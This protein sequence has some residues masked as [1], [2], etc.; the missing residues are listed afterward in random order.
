MIGRVMDR[1]DRPAGLV[2]MIAA[3]ALCG[4]VVALPL[5]AAHTPMMVDMPFHTAASSVFRHYF[6]PEWHFRE[7]FEL[8]LLQVP[9]LSFYGLIAGLMTLF[10]PLVATR[11]AIAVMLSMVPA[12]LAI[13]AWGLKKS[14]LLGLLG[15]FPVWG[16]LTHWGFINHMAAL[17][18][19]AACVGLALRLTQRP[20]RG[21]RWALGATLVLILFTHVYR[22]PFA[23]LAALGAGLFMWPDK[24]KLKPLIWPL[25]VSLLLFLIWLII[26]PATIGFNMG[27]GWPDLA[28]LTEIEQFLYDAFKG[29]EDDALYRRAVVILGAAAAGLSLGVVIRR[30]RRGWTPSAFAKRSHLLV[31]ACAAGFLVLYLIFPTWIGNWFYVYPRAITSAVVVG[32]ALIPNLPSHGLVRLGF[33]LIVGVALVPV[34]RH[35][36]EAHVEFAETTD[37]MWELSEELPHAPKLQYLIFNHSGAKIHQTPYVH[38]PAYLQAVHGGWLGWQFAWLGG[39]PLRFPD[40]DEPGAGVPPGPDAPWVWHPRQFEVNDEGAFFDWFL[41]RSKKDPKRFLAKDESIVFVRRKGKWWLF[42]RQPPDP[43]N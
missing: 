21:L 27:L 2:A 14:P 31:A 42:K 15:L 39:S 23:W 36:A 37:G 29:P 28:R 33:V 6:D 10:S 38:L 4:Y 35:V 24:D 11:I 1:I 7:Q 19:F 12:G 30:L 41:V 20:S 13:L 43:A 17:G 32:L 3:I 18:M 9:Y 40:R 26:R 5:W 34:S 25:T 22:F 8:Q 16:V